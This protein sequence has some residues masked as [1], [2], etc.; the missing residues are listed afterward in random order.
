MFNNYK[1]CYEE[2]NRKTHPY[3]KYWRTLKEMNAS[4]VKLGTEECELCNEYTIH[5]VEHQKQ[6]VDVCK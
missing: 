4:F 1:I 5:I 6:Q 3:I 2:E